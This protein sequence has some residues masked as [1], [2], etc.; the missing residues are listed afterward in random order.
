M[1]ATELF[2]KRLL[3]ISG[4]GGVGKSTLCAAFA[5]S[6]SRMGKN[7]L[8]VE[9]D[10]KER[11]SR[12]FGTPEVGY[13]GAFVH[14][15]IFVRNL[16]PML[17]MDEFIEQRVTVKTIARQIL[18]SA[19]Y[20]YFVAAA[21]GLKEFVTLGKIMLLEDE[22]NGQGNPKYDFIVVDA[23]ATGH[24]VAFLR[25][26]FAAMDVLRA[27]WVRKQ[28]DRIIQLLTDPAKT[29]LNIVTLPE[30]MPVNETI[31]MCQSVE[32]LLRIQIGYIIINSVY[33]QVLKNR[34]TALYD[35]MKKRAETDGLK[36][37]TAA[38]RKY[39]RAMIEGF[40][41]AVSRRELN[42]F[43]ISKLRRKL[44][45]DFMQIPFFFAKKFDLDLIEQVSDYMLESVKKG[46]K[47]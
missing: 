41:T 18:G 9:M 34:D 42:E 27:G 23:P 17:A 3:I 6:A 15:N 25:V 44:E 4:K 26:P 22:S 40:E 33:P 11:I 28:A 12:L 32:D 2:D 37:L 29:I 13:E 5:L 1:A 19:I 43:Y 36:K 14:P 47:G 39:A 7:V 31:E 45:Y 21:P 8:V 24:G 30:E 16:L 20:K 35:T 38:E 10:E 46:R